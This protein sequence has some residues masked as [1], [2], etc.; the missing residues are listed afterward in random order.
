MVL[1]VAPKAA[2]TETPM[3]PLEPLERRRRTPPESTVAMLETPN[4]ATLPPAEAVK[5]EQRVRVEAAAVQRQAKSVSRRVPRRSRA[6]TPAPATSSPKEVP[7]A[8]TPEISTDAPR[9]VR[10]AR[11]NRVA[12]ATAVPA[13][14]LGTA[15]TPEAAQAPREQ[16]LQVAN[17]SLPR[18]STAVP[19]Q[20]ATGQLVDR[21]APRMAEAPQTD[22]ALRA[23]A[24]TP[25]L[26]TAPPRRKVSSTRSR[27]VAS[28]TAAGVESDVV[29]DK[30]STAKSTAENS[31][32][33]AD[34]TLSRNVPRRRRQVEAPAAGLGPDDP[35]PAAATGAEI[36]VA[37]AVDVAKAVTGGP[38]TVRAVGR[39][40]RLRRLPAASAARSPP[41]RRWARRRW[42]WW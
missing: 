11:D 4:D 20:G 9:E 32:Q 22:Q 12:A 16:R 10:I 33:V 6:A 39:R 41:P 38:A 29:L 34:A 42:R 21:P 8:K 26:A 23:V 24:A 30:Q 5:Q 13:T 37:E 15:E 19:K 35:E 28:R 27:L 2:P 14:V 7:V 31:V 18:E 3:N 17:G 36:E 1:R 25:K 40:R